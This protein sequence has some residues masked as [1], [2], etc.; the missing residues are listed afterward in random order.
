[1]SFTLWRF[2]R[3]P[4]TAGLDLIGRR[5]SSV[6]FGIVNSLPEE[7]DLSRSFAASVCVCGFHH[8]E[9]SVFTAPDPLGA[10]PIVWITYLI[11]SLQVQ[12]HSK[13]VKPGLLP[14]SVI[15]VLGMTNSS[16]LRL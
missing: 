5:L 12:R 15:S 10:L 13:T 2:Q 16:K 8:L 7:S 4:E 6:S 11:Q 3:V 9:I 1:M 14:P